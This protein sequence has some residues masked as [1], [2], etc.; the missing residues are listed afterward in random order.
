MLRNCKHMETAGCTDD[1]IK[2]IDRL[3][4]NYP[5]LQCSLQSPNNFRILL[6]G[7][8]LTSNS[9]YSYTTYSFLD[10]DTRHHW[11]EL[12]DGYC[13]YQLN[14]DSYDVRIMSINFEENIIEYHVLQR[15]KISCSDE[16]LKCCV[17]I[18]NKS[19]CLI[20]IIPQSCNSDD[21]GSEDWDCV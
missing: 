14:W 11:E 3:N 18:W 16:A 21:S 17:F 13:R 19:R 9:S 5:Y 20:S 15:K 10:S 4:N 6:R 2:E 12:I 1:W 7:R 8:Q